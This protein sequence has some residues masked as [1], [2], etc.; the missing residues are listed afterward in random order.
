M[1]M[2][3][4][5]ITLLTTILEILMTYPV[6]KQIQTGGYRV[7]SGF[8]KPAY[9]NR[10]F[11]PFTIIALLF[12]AIYPLGTVFSFSKECVLCLIGCWWRLIILLIIK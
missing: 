5:I 11:M 10:K 2:L 8:E 1:E 7:F 9:F 3:S 4:I 12:A 6:L